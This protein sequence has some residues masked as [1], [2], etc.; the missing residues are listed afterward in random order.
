MTVYRPDL[1][2]VLSF[3]ADEVGEAAA[4]RLA[5]AR[6]G[7]ELMLPK[8]ATG[9]ELARIV[10]D[11]DA[12]RI[13]KLLGVGRVVVPAG[14]YAGQGARRRRAQAMLKD[15]K[16]LHEVAA[17]VG[18]DRSTVFRYRKAMKTDLYRQPELPFDS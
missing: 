4:I 15:G 3:I 13:I 17:A 5:T 10:G 8:R 16:S 2:G 14:A 6:G 18:L 11:E 7:R 9:S 12:E 1:P